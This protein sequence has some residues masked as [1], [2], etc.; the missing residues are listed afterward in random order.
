MENPDTT[1]FHHHELVQSTQHIDPMFKARVEE[2]CGLG[3]K[4]KHMMQQLLK[5]ATWG[6]LDHKVEQQ[7]IGIRKR[8]F[9]CRT[10][11]S[12]KNTYA[13]LLR[14]FQ[15]IEVRRSPSRPKPM[16]TARTCWAL[17]I[18]SGPVTV[19]ALQNAEPPILLVR[20]FYYSLL[21]FHRDI[22]PII[23]S[24]LTRQIR[25]TSR[26]WRITRSSE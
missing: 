26:A 19:T 9:A 17:T 18:G 14:W 6:E 1:K 23:L 12:S 16:G 13:E 15:Q 4:P 25:R 20:F 8:F 10:P 7:V 22:G 11:V 21:R 3:L 24:R 5:D 2:L